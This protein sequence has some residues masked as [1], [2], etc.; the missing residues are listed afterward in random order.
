LLAFLNQSIDLYVLV[1]R[2]GD[3]G[4]AGNVI[5]L[6]ERECSLQRRNQKVVEEAPSGAKTA[7]FVHFVY[8]MHHFAKTGS[9]QT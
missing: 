5:Y 2:R 9:G 8:K 4:G 1:A 3:D 7:L 6:N